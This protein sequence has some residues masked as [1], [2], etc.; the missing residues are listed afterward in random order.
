VDRIE[1]EAQ[2][3]DPQLSISTV[4]AEGGRVRAIVDVA[5][6]AQ[7][8]VVG[9]ETRHG[10]ERV[11]TG[12]TTAGVASNA[13]CPVT[14]VPGS[15]EPRPD[16]ESAGTVAVGIR[17]AADA[18]DL[19]ATAYAWASARRGSITLVHAWEMANPYIDRIE[20]RTHA[21]EWEALGQQLLDD[22]L[23]DWRRQHPD[24]P[25]ETRVI[26]GH[27]ASVLVEAAK[28]ADLVV[29]RRAHPHR[30]FDHLGATV[31]ALLLASPTP[32]EV[33]PA[34]RSSG[35]AADLVLED[36]GRMAK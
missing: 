16:P 22:A 21:D 8:V 5:G 17:R 7:L 32:V 6:E 9:R 28:A 36:A 4:L 14:V 25:V 13:R 35:P 2:A 31:R 3:L 18:Q 27:A 11:L 1:R 23:K 34:L 29:V 30:P 10:L 12:T 15:R 33:V 24:V 19:M 20:A 26:H